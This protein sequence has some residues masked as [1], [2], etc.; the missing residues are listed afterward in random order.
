MTSEIGT[1]PAPLRW[2][3]AIQ[4]LPR[5]ESRIP[6][7]RLQDRVT[8]AAVSLRGWPYPGRPTSVAFSDSW[9]DAVVEWQDY[10]ERWRFHT[11]GLFTHRWR[12]REDDYPRFR[13]T[14]NWLSATW[15]LTE[16][17]EFAKRLYGK[18]QTVDAARVLLNIE[19]LSG[20]IASGPPEY[21]VRSTAPAATNVFARDLTLAMP[22][23]VADAAAPAAAWAQELLLLLNTA[24]IPLDV[25][26][27]HQLRLV[28]RG[29]DAPS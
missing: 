1:N 8:E 6:L 5:L 2:S 9:I 4:P 28:N 26:R 13:N 25:I 17:W 12:G 20:R 3:V 29:D 16:I 24:V 21:G 14:L 11:D 19:G 27:D 23:L 18:D 10:H 15:T 22:I 7:V